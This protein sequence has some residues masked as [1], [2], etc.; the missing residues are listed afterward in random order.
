MVFQCWPYGRD[1]VQGWIGGS[2][3]R[4]LATAGD[5]AVTDFALSELRR[6]FGGRVGGC[7]LMARGW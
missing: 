4:A 7:S 2:P 6:V 1:Y 3:A 5:A